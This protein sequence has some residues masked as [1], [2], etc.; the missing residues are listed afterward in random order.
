[1]PEL[2]GVS[3]DICFDSHETKDCKAIENIAIV[4]HNSGFVCALKGDC[5]IQLSGGRSK[6]FEC[7]VKLLKYIHSLK[8]RCKYRFDRAE[9]YLVKWASDFLKHVDASVVIE[10]T[11]RLFNETR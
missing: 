9:T 2:Q 3:C 11:R 4:F 1:M 6:Y 7:N 8:L 5:Y 10:H